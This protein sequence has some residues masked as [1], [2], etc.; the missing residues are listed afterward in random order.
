MPV[1]SVTSG[2]LKVCNEL[3]GSYGGFLGILG[4]EGSRHHPY[5]Y[6]EGSNFLAADLGEANE[7]Q[8]HPHELNRIIILVDFT[9]K[10]VPYRCNG[11]DGNWPNL[12]WRVLWPGVPC[13]VDAY[14]IGRQAIVPVAIRKVFCVNQGGTNDPLPS[15]IDTLFEKQFII[16]H[17]VR[18]WKESKSD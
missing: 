11:V 9:T 3:F 8:G 15:N 12:P 10:F 6:I 4:G 16:R 17:L 5:P 2:D 1:P 13:G 14:C 18:H 7:I